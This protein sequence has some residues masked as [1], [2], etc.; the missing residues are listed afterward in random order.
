MERDFFMDATEALEYGL[1][2]QI[3]NK[4]PE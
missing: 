2:D 3:V 4:R 1:I